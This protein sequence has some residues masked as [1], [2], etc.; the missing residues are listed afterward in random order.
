MSMLRQIDNLIYAL[1]RS[2]PTVGVV[3]ISVESADYDITK[4]SVTKETRR[5]KLPRA[6]QLSQETVQKKLLNMMKLGSLSAATQMDTMLIVRAKYI[7]DGFVFDK[8]C[9]V[10]IGTTLYEIVYFETPSEI[11]G[12]LVGLRGTGA[13]NPVGEQE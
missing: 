10:Q 13:A 11:R 4:G 5:L 7:K 12:Y 1:E 6:V 2:A 9:K 3:L 8:D